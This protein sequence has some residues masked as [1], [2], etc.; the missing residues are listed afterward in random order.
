MPLSARVMPDHPV[1]VDENLAARARQR[2][3]VVGRAELG[4]HPARTAARAGLVRVQP[5]S[6]VAATQPITAHVL[7]AAVREGLGDRAHAFLGAAAL[8]LHEAGPVPEVIVVGVP[9]ARRLTVRP[10]LVTRRVSPGVLVG[11]RSRR[12]CQVVA[13]EVAVIQ[14]ASARSPAQVVGLVEN[15][16]RGR[17]TSVGALRERCSRGLTGSAAVR[18]ALAELGSESLDRA[19]RLLYEALL[20]RG[21]TGLRSEVH[22]VSAA[23]ASCYA[24]LLHQVSR[25]VLEVDGFL[26]H[27]QRD[28]FRADR[29]RD[30]WLRAEHGLTTL[31][32]DAAEVF[33]DVGRL[34]AELLPLLG[35]AAS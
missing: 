21:V 1:N 18:R 25:T 26:P 30:R 19:V 2:Y 16:L 5:R 13:L 24:D 17:R 23:G 35:H 12:G 33:E 15:L 29:R 7:V 9:H 27:T 34:A 22:F 20:D 6:W 31:R 11:A 14:V 10:P 4:D 8:W 3:G 32:V 28:R